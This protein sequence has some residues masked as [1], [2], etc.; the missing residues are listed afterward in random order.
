ML[1]EWS[2]SPFDEEQYDGA[3]QKNKKCGRWAEDKDAGQIY[4]RIQ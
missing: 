2:G 3:E 1:P 4:G